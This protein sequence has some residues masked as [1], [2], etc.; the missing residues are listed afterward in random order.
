MFYFAK[1][2]LDTTISE[3]IVVAESDC[4]NLEFPQSEPV[5]QSFLGSLGKG[6]LWLQTSIDRAYRKN[7]ASFGCMYISSLDIFTEPQ[8]YPSWSLDENGDWQAPVSKPDQDGF[9]YWD[10]S[11]QQWVR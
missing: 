6:G 11:E 2:E 10:E 1:V 5:G 9:W 7:F 8:P 4:D 3:V